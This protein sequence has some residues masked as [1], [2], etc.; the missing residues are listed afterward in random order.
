MNSQT[1]F[2]EVI[3][4]S[5]QTFTAQ[6]WAW[7]NPP[8][9]GSIVSLKSGSKTLFGVVFSV[10]TGALDG[11]RQPFAYQK[12][13]EELKREQPQIFEFLITTFECLILGYQEKTSIIYQWA[14]EPPKI[15][16]FVSPAT[17]QELA[18]IC[19]LDQYLH[20]IFNAVAVVPNTDEL[21]LALFKEQVDNKLLS[22]ERLHELLETFSLLTGND[23][24]RLKLFLQRAAFLTMTY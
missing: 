23:Y 6:T 15:H 4:S 5:L 14:P 18:V 20:L 16:T 7:D 13:E 8:R 11:H 2:A 21:L 19:A 9:F 1:A 10:K 22:R 24:R 3:E 12:T 17:P